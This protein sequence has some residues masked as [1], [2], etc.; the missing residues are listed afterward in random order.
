MRR[1]ANIANFLWRFIII[2]ALIVHLASTF[3][4]YYWFPWI[5]LQKN[6]F[7]PGNR[8]ATNMHTFYLSEYPDDLIRLSGLI[9]DIENASNI[10]LAY[11]QSFSG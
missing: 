8:S 7:I 9:H 4:T 3:I 10:P 1:V 6:E 11:T 2:S 5:I